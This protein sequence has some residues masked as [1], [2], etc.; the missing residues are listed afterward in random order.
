MG[1]CVLLVLCQDSPHHKPSKGSKSSNA[2]L[3]DS[4]VSGASTQGHD[5]KPKKVDH[6]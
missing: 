3:A 2:S 5:K 6:H 4:S 1:V